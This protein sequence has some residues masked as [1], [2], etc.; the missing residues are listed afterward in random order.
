MFVVFYPT[1]A[2]PE[3]KAAPQNIC[4]NCSKHFFSFLNLIFD[5]DQKGIFFSNKK[6]VAFKSLCGRKPLCLLN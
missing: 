4:R 2:E 5:F 1:M 6:N 3:G